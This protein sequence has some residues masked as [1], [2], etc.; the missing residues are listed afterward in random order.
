MSD[1]QAFTYYVNPTGSGASENNLVNV[2]SPSWVL[3]FVRWKYRD[4]Y[5]IDDTINAN[6]GQNTNALAAL[7]ATLEPLVVIN[8]CINV[9]VTSNKNTFTPNM[10]AT[11]LQTDVNYLTAIAPGDFVLVNMVNWDSQATDIYNR[12]HSSNPGNINRFNDGFKGIFKIQSVRRTTAI[13]DQETGKKGVVF[14]ITGHAFTEFNNMLYFDPSVAL[15]TDGALVFAAQISEVWQQLVSANK[16]QSL[17]DLIKTLIISFIGSSSPRQATATNVTGK[18]YQTPNDKFYMPGVIGKLLGI[19]GGVQYASDIYNYWFGIQTYTNTSSNAS[20]KVGLNPA[21]NEAT[22]TEGFYYTTTPCAGRAIL[23]PEYWNQVKAWDILNQYINSPLNEFFTCFR[24][25]PTDGTILPTVVLRQIPFTNEDFF[26]N[27]SNLPNNVPV[28]MYMNIPRWKISPTLVISQDIGRDEV[29]RVNYVQVFARLLQ[30]GALG[31]DYTLESAN[32]N[33]KFDLNDIQRSGLRP[34]VTASM[35]DLYGTSS[36]R[37]SFNSPIW[38]TIYADAVIGGHLKMNGSFVCA[39]I[40]DPIAVGD[41]LEFEDIVYHIEQITHTCS[42]NP[43]NGIKS[44]RTIISVSSGLSIYSNASNGTSYPEMAYTNAYGE[45][46]WDY[47]RSQILPGVSESQAVPYRLPN[48]D[49]IN[50]P[51]DQP[52]NSLPQP[53]QTGIFPDQQNPTNTGNNNNGQ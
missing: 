48:V 45:R 31:S 14:K 42:I 52:N 47:K 7:K 37:V 19:E 34:K 35:F 53:K 25:D 10:E 26:V 4:T 24:A 40:P 43:A 5:R 27:N 30:G 3:T 22:S 2:T 6:P 1:S 17:Q 38:A 8:D 11:L 21:M 50:T 18:N 44:F 36:S 15:Q 20:P 12:A 9:S 46:E 32:H 39:G 29:M 23:S 13:V 16:D 49:D 28:T 33:Y 41:N 51:L